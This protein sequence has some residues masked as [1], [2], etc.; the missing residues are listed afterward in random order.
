[1]Q[2]RIHA[3]GG[4][5]KSRSMRARQKMGLKCF[6]L[7]D[8]RG[9]FLGELCIDPFKIIRILKIETPPQRAPARHNWLGSIVSR[10]SNGLKRRHKVVPA[11]RALS[12]WKISKQIV[13]GGGIPATH[14][15]QFMCKLFSI[16]FIILEGAGICA[17]KLRPKSKFV[18]TGV[19][20]V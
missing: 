17:K 15:G 13:A 12:K 14:S 1:M 20:I 18:K 10:C 16:G 9:R 5:K 7:F 11:T 3:L 4:G 2:A 6:G 8:V 19:C